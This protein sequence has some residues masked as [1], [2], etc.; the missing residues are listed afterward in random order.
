MKLKADGNNVIRNALHHGYPQAVSDHVHVAQI[1][2]D[3]D[4]CTANSGEAIKFLKMC[5]EQ[6]AIQK[7][8]AKYFTTLH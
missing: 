2:M 1:S 3:N 8:P 7:G 5:G 6:K 4:L